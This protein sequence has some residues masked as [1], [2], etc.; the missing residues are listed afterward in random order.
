MKQVLYWHLVVLLLTTS[1]QPSQQ[2][3]TTD[4]QPEGREEIKLPEK[5]NI[6]WIV[7]E[8]LGPYIPDFGD[9]TIETPTL[10]RLAAEGIC[11]DHF[12]SPSGVC[13]PSR[14]AIATGMYPT[15]IA[16]NHMRT[17]G[18]LMPEGIPPHEAMPGPEVRMFSE[19]LRAQGYYCTNNSKED[20]Q[21]KKTPT[22]WDESSR[23]AH[24]RNRAEGQ[25]FFA[26]FNIG[27]T[28]ESQI[29]S[30]AE[31]SLWVDPNLKVPVPPYLPD[32]KVGQKDV[33]R[34]YSNVRMMD[35]MAGELIQELEDEGLLESTIIFWYADHGGPLPRMKRLCYDSGLRVPLIIR[36]PNKQMAGSRNDDLLNFIDLAP[37]MLSLVGIQPLDY[38]DGQAFLGKYKSVEPRQYVHAAGDRFDQQYD[39]IRAVK[40]KRFKYIRYYQPEKPMYLPVAYREQMA[41][42]QELLRMRDAG[43]LNEVQSQWF[44]ET[45]PNEELFDT[46]SDPHEIKD[47]SKD[48]RYA[49]KLAELSAECDRWVNSFWDTGLIPESELMAKIWPDGTQPITADPVVQQEKDQVRISSATKG[50]SIGYKIWEGAE[51]PES[52]MV[53]NGPFLRTEG[54]SVK[55]VAHRLGFQRSEEVTLD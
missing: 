32:N 8:D 42:M 45:K 36:F 33:R 5:P 28:H 41:I 54:S 44:R 51:E 1:C 40:D 12:Y 34:M 38:F 16:A 47:I 18:R 3:T 17:G 48:P 31:D 20:Y 10:S 52:W 4:A 21:F 6:V 19:Y 24:W 2:S 29:W 13:A 49:D 55:A 7:T 50:A 46:Q 39:M 11:Y 22:A 25:P 37:T 26:I 23:D 35:Y 43:E 9:P 15:H 14:A 53:Y 27:V 30:R